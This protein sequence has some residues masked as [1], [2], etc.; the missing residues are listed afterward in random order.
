MASLSDD[1]GLTKPNILRAVTAGSAIA[2]RMVN[3]TLAGKPIESYWGNATVYD[4][5]GNVSVKFD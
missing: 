2:V 1:N 5:A 3:V 4:V